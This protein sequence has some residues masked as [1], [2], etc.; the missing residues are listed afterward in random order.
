MTS[1]PLTTTFGIAGP[2][3]EGGDVLDERLGIRLIESLRPAQLG[4]VGVG[5]RHAAGAQD[6]VGERGARL[7]DVG[8]AGA[9]C[10][11]GPWQDAQVVRNSSSPRPATATPAELGASWAL[12][13]ATEPADRGDRRPDDR[14]QGDVACD[15]S[16]GWMGRRGLPR[17]SR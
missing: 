11:C 4:R 5:E 8:P 3:A 12:A 6:E 16:P 14:D 15:E 2:I 10:P 13:T 1:A 7:A 9:P 17:G